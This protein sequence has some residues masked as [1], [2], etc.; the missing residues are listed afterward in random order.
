M[1]CVSAVSY[2]FLLGNEVVGKVIPQRGIMQGDPLSPYIF[3][4]CAEVL[5]GLCKKAQMEGSLPGLRVSRNS[6]K[7]NHLLFA[8]NTMIFTKTDSSSCS[9]LLEILHTYEQASGQMINPQ[10]SSITFSRKTPREIRERVKLQLGINKDGGVG[11]YLGLPEEF[12]RKKKRPPLVYCRRM[13]Q[14]SICWS[15]QFLS[16][17]GKATMLQSVL[18]AIPTF[19]MICFDLPVSLCKRIQSVLTRF[20]WDSKDGEKGRFAGCLDVM[21]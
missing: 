3:I 21:G 14:R 2:S 20:L 1:Q 8:D 6:L 12:G 15:T 7:L 9:S 5:S 10:K 16:T 13:K 4:L 17:A 18:S 19:A 11:K